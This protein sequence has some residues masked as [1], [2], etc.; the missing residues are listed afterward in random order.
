MSKSKYNVVNPDDIVKQYGADTF[1]MYE[2]FLGPIEISKPWD[3]KGIEGV[4][5]FIKRFWRL[6]NDEQ[7]GWIVSDE[8]ATEAELKTLHRT[9]KKVEEATERFSFNTAV[10]QF[11]IC[12]NEL[13][14]LKCNKREILEPLVVLIAAY[15]PHMAEELWS[16][17]GHQDSVVN[18][19]YP[20]W[21]EKYTVDNS[22]V[23]PVA[24][25]GKTRAEME[26][27][28]DAS[29]A[30]IEAAVFA[31]EK[32]QGYLEGKTPKKIIFVKGKMINIV[33]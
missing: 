19:A 12:V 32:I 25:N 28:L 3:T 2:M 5:K 11:M 27:A 10:S 15:A 7:K 29:Q 6:F 30:D 9:I 20:N 16:Q 33:L 31:N 17:L 23:Y 21:E 8:A 1:R 22:K 26:F 18:A 4:N 24:I 14:D 13:M